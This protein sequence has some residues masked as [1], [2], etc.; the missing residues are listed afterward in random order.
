MVKKIVLTGGPCT[1]KTT[2]LDNIRDYYS[3][4]GFRVIVVSE[5]AT[6]IINDGI[7]CFGIDK[8]VD[9][10]DFQELVL[11]LQLLKEDIVDSVV[12]Y[13]TD[14][15]ILVVYDRGTLD[16]EAYVNPETFNKVMKRV[17]PSLTREKLL[18]RYD[19]V[20]VL[21]GDKSFYTL[22][23]NSARKESADEALEIGKKTLMSWV[24]H[25]NLKLVF[26]KDTMKEKTNEVIEDIRESFAQDKAK[27]S[28][29]VNLEN[30][31]LDNILLEAR[32]KDYEE[33]EIA[34]SIYFVAHQ[35]ACSLH[36]Y[37][38]ANQA[39]LTVD[40]DVSDCQA[41]CPQLCILE[42]ISNMRLQL[43]V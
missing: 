1:G 27:K 24:E 26:P 33:G 18:S 3:K 5:T 29:V 30:S 37:R 2:V 22:E 32:V 42:E 34:R 41:L 13:K 11:R 9:V 4:N 12:R 7:K 10:V 19:M 16:G 17:D 15:D 38:D 21:I 20:L 36:I 43:K 39:L 25:D 31:S 28:Y 14:E 23:T 8:L 6:E 40:A 35:K